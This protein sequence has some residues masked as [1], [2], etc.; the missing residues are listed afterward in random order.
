MTNCEWINEI[1]KIIRNNIEAIG[2]I[3]SDIKAQ[4]DKTEMSLAD[5]IDRLNTSE[6]L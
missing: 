3:F 2:C 4:V 1:D 5:I 6:K